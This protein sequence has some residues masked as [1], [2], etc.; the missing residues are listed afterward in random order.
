MKKFVINYNIKL[1]L[2]A[3]SVD[4]YRL[5]NFVL[6]KD[7]PDTDI[8]IKENDQSNGNSQQGV[9]ASNDLVSYFSFLPRMAYE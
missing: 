3:R 5:Y 8:I 7:M 2:C 9:F 4:V 6:V 1:W